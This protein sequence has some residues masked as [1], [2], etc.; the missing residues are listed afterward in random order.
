M[1]SGPEDET[2]AALLRAVCVPFAARLESTDQALPLGV[3]VSGGGDSMALLHLLHRAAPKAGLRLHCVTVDHGLRPEAKAEAEGVA[4][5]C[6]GLGLTHETLH[7]D[8]PAASGNLMDQARRARLTLIADWARG[9]GIAHVAIGHTADDQAESFLMNLS[10][11]AGLEGL[12]GMRPAWDEQ[13]VH[14]MRPLLGQGRQALRDYLRRNGLAWVDDPSNE[15]PKYQ[16]V[17]ARQAMR[18][19]HPLGVTAETIGQSIAH[20]SAADE[21]LLQITAAVAAGFRETAGALFIPD[22][23]L[24]HQPAEIR[25][26]LLNGMIRWIGGADY[27]PRAHQLA[28]L[29]GLLQQGR[30]ATLGGTRFRHKN[31]QILA[32]REARATQGAV[33]LGEVWDNRWLVTGDTGGETGAATGAEVRALGAAGLAQIPDWRDMGLPREAAL[34]LPGLWQQDRLI[35]APYFGFGKGYSATIRFSFHRFLLSH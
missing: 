18:D 10:R 8:G 32:L 25:R 12:S 1:S 16:R 29:E 6:A 26:R 2:D 19:L 31:G 13:G 30:D 9:R 21:A 27:P 34:V 4:A 14:W 23:I 33:S 20:L 28:R 17:R 11:A 3:A 7:W 5:F 15:N 35:S 24:W 22:D